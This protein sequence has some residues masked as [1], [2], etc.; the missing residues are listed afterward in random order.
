MA[1]RTHAWRSR[2]AVAFLFTLLLTTAVSVIG[3]PAALAA[4]PL[5]IDKTSGPNPVASGQQLTY[6]IVVTNTIGSKVTEVMLTDVVQGMTGVDGTNRL[7]LTSSIGSCGQSGNTV[8]CSA[9]ML[10]GFESWTVTIRGIVTA[11]NGTVLTNTAT[12]TG[13]Q[14]ATT[15]TSTDTVQTQVAGAN[16]TPLPDLNVT[17]KGP[18][19]I[20]PSDDTVYTVTV[21]NLG[22]AKASDVDLAITMPNDIAFVDTH[23]TSLFNC[24]L[25]PAQ[26]ETTTLLCTGGAVNAGTNATVQV[27][28]VGPDFAPDSVIITAAV[29]PNNTIAEGNELNN[30]SQAT[31]EVTVGPPAGTLA[32]DKS[33]ASDPIAPG[34][35]LTYTLVMTNTSEH[36]ADYIEVVDGTQGLEAASVTANAV[37][38]NAANN[39]V[40]M[41]CTVSAPTVSCTTT[42]FY[43]GTVATITITGVVTAT[44][45]STILNTA[46]VN[47]NIRNT[48]VTNTSSAITVVRPSRDLTVTQHRTAPAIPTPVRAADRFDY[49]ITVG[50]SG[51]Y[52]ANNVIVREPLPYGADSSVTTEDVYFDSFVGSVAGTTC[53]VDA[54]NVLTCMIPKVKGANS[55]GETEG[56][57]E[58]ILIKLIA[59]HQTG[60]ITTTVTVD[61]ANIIPENDESN[62]TYTTTTSVITGIDLTVSK[63]ATPS[64]VARNGTLKYTIT[65]ENLGT[66]DAQNIVV[67]DTLPFGT[68]FRSATEVPA[69]TAPDAPV[70]HGFTC[71]A[72][73]NVV[74]CIGGHI[75]GTYSGSLT[76][77]VDKAVI[78][79]DVFAPDEPGIYHNEVRVDPFGTIPE[80]NESNN[81]FLL[82]VS[83]EN[84]LNTPAQG[85]Y[86]ELFIESL[87]EVNAEPPAYAT[88]GVLDYNLTVRNSGQSPAGAPDNLVVRI[89]LPAGSTYRAAYDLGGLDNGF[90]CSYLG[91]STV[92]CSGGTVEALGMRQIRIE[93]FAPASPGTALIQAI[94]DPANVIGE[95]DETNNSN[96]ETTNIQAGEADTAPPQVQG[97]YIDLKVND[98]VDSHDPVA[99]SGTLDY[100]VSLKNTGSADAFG[101]TFTAA[102]PAG[103]TFRS[104]DDA[105]PADTASAFDCSESG[106]VV[107]CT[108]GRING[109]AARVVKIRVFAPSQPSTSDDATQARLS[110]IVDPNNAVPEG[111]EGNNAAEELTKVQINGGGTQGA[112]VDLKLTQAD[113]GVVRETDKAASPDPDDGSVIPGGL[114]TYTLDVFNEGTDD[115]FNVTV[116]N[117]LAAGATFVSAVPNDAASNFI[118]QQANGI[119]TCTGGYMPGT[120][121][122][123]V[124]VTHRLITVK[125]KAPMEHDIDMNNQAFVD[126]ENAIAEAS[127]VNNTDIASNPVKS[128]VDLKVTMQNGDAGTAA[129]GHWKFSAENAI[130][131]DNARADN[132]KLVA[133]FSGGSIQI[134]TNVTTSNGNWNCSVYENPVN[135][136]VCVGKFDK[137]NPKVDVDVHYYQTSDNDIHG[138]LEVDP[139]EDTADAIIGRV[140]ETV[141]N[142]NTAQSTG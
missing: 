78:E 39:A 2:G 46:T 84:G 45:G 135:Q 12:V 34:E 110:V 11:A 83:V 67:R 97:T 24:A 123:T 101:V 65:V 50:N 105:A 52:D 106:G 54:S 75:E 93:T 10:R 96:D 5:T 68:V 122:G 44:P 55:A 40:P 82:D 125:V 66:Q 31:T 29:D 79:I 128:V 138:F 94:V 14:S 57:T 95:A 59:P 20:L 85:A 117:P 35:T 36:R 53:S 19:T 60:D 9:R 4:N 41:T 62:N 89:S 51:L 72:S 134:D 129:E 58:T 107:T 132:V 120:N 104:A 33:D 88:S 49:T 92:E 21:N 80:I 63:I 98:I 8:T 32:I 126:P 121:N 22:T 127:E 6:T 64:P 87:D 136:V 140:V 131:K 81:L 114:V 16:N 141:E 56:S 17:I 42:R 76:E 48:G 71:S 37:L 130:T 112:F 13:T 102:L 26:T 43:P 111:H 91:G 69:S 28:V 103:S 139:E 99:T 38:T 23:A 1:G 113:Q 86:K 142:N 3:A 15:Y 108:G 30:A 18:N 119:V 124:A 133:N 109:G 73:G 70:Y 74:D 90:V 118:C 7:V 116:R 100:A 47:G 25:Q 77:L 61:P 27:G 137:D 115:A